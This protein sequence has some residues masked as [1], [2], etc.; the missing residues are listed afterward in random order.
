[1]LEHPRASLVHTE[2]YM[3]PV[4]AARM[5]AWYTRRLLLAPVGALT[6]VDILASF[7]ARTSPLSAGWSSAAPLRGG[8][9]EVGILL[10]AGTG[11]F[12][13]FHLTVVHRQVLEIGTKDTGPA[14]T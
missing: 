3:V 4:A 8:S 12:T 9:R 11:C 13:I 2:Y 10:G 7:R 6:V 14:Y 1:M 5:A